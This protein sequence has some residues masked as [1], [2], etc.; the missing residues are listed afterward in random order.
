MAVT[1]D[2]DNLVVTDATITFVGGANADEAVTTQVAYMVITSSGV[3]TSLPALAA[4]DPGLPPEL[5]FTYTEYPPDDPLPATNPAVT[6]VDAGGAGVAS[7]YDITI[8]GHQGV[9]GDDGTASVLDA[10]D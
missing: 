6:L 5:S 2:G 10:S 9:T 4:G 8:Y 7:E 3:S 1:I